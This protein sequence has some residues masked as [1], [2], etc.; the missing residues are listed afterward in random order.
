MLNY[1]LMMPEGILVLKPH[2]PLSKEDFDGV[3][4][5]VDAYLAD[6]PKLHGILIHTSGFPGWENFG[7]FAAH[8]HFVQEHHKKVERVAVVTDSY[9]AGIAE[10]LGRHFLAAEIKHFPFAD[11][12]RALEWLQPKNEVPGGAPHEEPAGRKQLIAHASTVI[13]APADKVWEA[14]ID[15]VAVKQYMFGANVVSSWAV[16]RAITWTGEYNGKKYA[17]KGV[18]LAFDPGKLL[19]YTHFSPLAGKPD[20][21]ENYHTVTI[22][23]SAR[24]DET[25]VSLSQDNN[26]SDESRAELTK[27]WGTMLAELKKY[28]ESALVAA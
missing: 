20:V 14:L 2:A 1:S 15:P 18:I 5:L 16:G 27:N 19:Q 7:G 24:N 6:Q 25:E 17:D 11:D 10:S 8:M 4:A 13:D 3:S 12:A 21:P 28:V 22:H 26:A 9:I 23:L